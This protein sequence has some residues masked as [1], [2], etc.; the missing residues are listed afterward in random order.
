M[1]FL[2]IEQHDN[3]AVLSLTR[4]KVNPLNEEMVDKISAAISKLKEDDSAKVLIIT[5]SDKFFS[6]GLDVPELY[7]YSQSD[8][9]RFLVKFTTLYTSLFLF[10]KPVIMAI[11]GHAIAGGC[12]LAS[13]GDYRLM[14]TGRARISLNEV[15]FGSSVFAGSVEMLK[16]IVGGRNAETILLAGEMFSAEEAEKLGLVDKVVSGEN[17]LKESFSLAEKLLE[18]DLRAYTSIKHLLRKP[19]A[20]QMIELES[21]SIKEFIDIW[22]SE[23]T[24]EQLKG[25]QIR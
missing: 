20:R 15:T 2:K 1:P 5:G 25:I 22:Y 8:F 12:M 4:G 6:F 7:S 10:P 13:A 19:V 16:Y 18:K 14:V 23:S 3:I 24:R 9:E 17:L 11:N 21:G